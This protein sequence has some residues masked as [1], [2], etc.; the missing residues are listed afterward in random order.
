MLVAE[1]PQLRLVAKSMIFHLPDIIGLLW[2]GSELRL[3]LAKRSKADAVSK[4]RHSLA[5]IWLVI[6]PAIALGGVAARRLPGC[7]LPWPGT[8]QCVSAGLFVAG[9]V[10]RWLAIRHL[11]RFFTTNVAIAKDH[12][13]VDSG[14]YR[15]VRHPSYTGSLVAAFGFALSFSNGASLLIIFAPYAAVIL[16]RIRIEEQALTGALGR[17]Y[18]AYM[19]RTK[20]L[21]PKVF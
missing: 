12:R 16:W 7:G 21:I 2:G 19:R 17:D 10:L 5:I 6:L 4:D 11:G 3:A 20:R 8:I 13:L 1:A 15:L 18:T 14:P 9:T